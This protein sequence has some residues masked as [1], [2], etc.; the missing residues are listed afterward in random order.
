MPPD[1]HLVRLWQHD[2]YRSIFLYL[3][4]PGARRQFKVARY[5]SFSFTFPSLWSF[6]LQAPSYCS[7]ESYPESD[8]HQ[9]Q[10][11]R[12]C[13]RF[14]STLIM[15][16]APLTMLNTATGQVIRCEGAAVSAMVSNLLGTILNI[17]LDPYF[18]LSTWYADSG[19]CHRNTDRYCQLQR[20]LYSLYYKK[21]SARLRSTCAILAFASGIAASVLAIG[22]PSGISTLLGPVSPASLKIIFWWHGDHYVKF[23]LSVAGRATMIIGMF[24]DRCCYGCPAYHFL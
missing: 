15:L 5:S 17:I 2:W 9:C 1:N 23:T 19:G 24:T 6:C 16:G 14:L 7:S 12:L 10:H 8:R 20:F 13:R 4:C 22:L 11:P 3:G 18:Y 21:M